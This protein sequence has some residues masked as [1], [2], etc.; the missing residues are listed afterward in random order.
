MT[1][2]NGLNFSPYKTESAEDT[3]N[4]KKTLLQDDFLKLLTAQ[5][6]NQD[7]LSPVDDSQFLAQL[8]Q[9]SALEQMNSVAQSVKELNNNMTWL[10]SQSLLTQGAAMIGKE[11]VAVG[12]DGSEIN[13]VISSI[14]VEAGSL[15]VVI[16]E[17]TVSIDGIREIRQSGT[18]TT[19]TPSQEEPAAQESTDSTLIM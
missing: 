1:T 13:G 3:T 15:N 2:I 12:A 4:D 5:L 8:A 18:V 16:G 10:A 19:S 17:E 6:K 11:A 9:F 7:P 14:K